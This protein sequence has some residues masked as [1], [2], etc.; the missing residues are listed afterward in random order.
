MDPG[1]AQSGL[2]TF[3]QVVAGQAGRSISE[4][5]SDLDQEDLFST[6]NDKTQAVLNF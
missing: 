4:I 1:S 5:D 2:I 6:A 3:A